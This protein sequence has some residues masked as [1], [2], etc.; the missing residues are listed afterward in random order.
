MEAKI[1]DVTAHNANFPLDNKRPHT[2]ILRNRALNPPPPPSSLPESVTQNVFKLLGG[3]AD[4]L[5]DDGHRSQ[6]Q[7]LQRAQ[8]KPKYPAVL[9][10]DR[11]VHLVGTQKQPTLIA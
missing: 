6:S 9:R 7:S 10:L 1:N 4:K 3:H 11:S 2:R 5:T 8:P